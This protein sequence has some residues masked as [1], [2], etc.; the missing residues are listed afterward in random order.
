V[1]HHVLGGQPI[2]LDR[3]VEF[4]IG[5]GDR[6]PISRAMRRA[7]SCFRSARTLATRCQILVR[8]T[9]YV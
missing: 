2:V 8:A 5:F 6:L 4:L 3:V 1:P 9:L 7:I